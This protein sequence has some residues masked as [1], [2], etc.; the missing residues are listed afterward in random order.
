MLRKSLDALVNLDPALAREVCRVD[1]EVD[2]LN[3]DVFRHVKEG[4]RRRLDDLSPLLHLLCVARHIE[5]IADLATNIAEDVIYMREG[6]IVR[7]KVEY[8]DG[9]RAGENGVQM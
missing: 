6:E 8:F 2:A 9:E 4:V 3:R 5:R 1:G 7:H